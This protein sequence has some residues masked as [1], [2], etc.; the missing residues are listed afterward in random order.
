M[1]AGNVKDR[2]SCGGLDHGVGPKAVADWM[3]LF[4]RRRLKSSAGVTRPVLMGTTL[5]DGET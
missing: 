5:K 2:T 1:R 3:A 4:K